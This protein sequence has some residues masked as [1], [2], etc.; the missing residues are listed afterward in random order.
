MQVKDDFKQYSGGVYHNKT[1]KSVGGHAV[2]VVGY[3]YEVQADA[4]DDLDNF[5]WVIANSWGPRFGEK[6][7]FR[8]SFSEVIGY[9]AS[10][11]TPKKIWNQSVKEL[12]E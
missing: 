9:L 2:K 7:F 6:G 3:G 4:T 8:I 1:A 10:A 12:L 5:Y 11:L